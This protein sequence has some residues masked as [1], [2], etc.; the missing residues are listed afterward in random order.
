MPGDPIADLRSPSGS[1]ISV[2][3]NRPSP[4]GFGALVSDL[5]RPIREQSERLGRNVQK[6]VQ[7]DSDRIHRLVDRL[8]LEAAPAYAIFASD[9]D[10]IFILEPLAYSAVN[11]SSL[12]PRPY[13][14]P[15]RAAPR[16]LRA[17]IIVAD[18]AEARTFVSFSGLIDDVGEPLAVETRKANYGGF[19]GYDEHTVR[20]H[21]DEVSHRVWKEAGLRILEEHQRKAFDYIA[22]GS[23]EENC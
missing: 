23:H 8:E 16:G 13:M 4:G 19:S 3:I 20:G 22:I 1:L 14:R 17:G 11:V 9:L 5:V 21:A 10:D 2:F 15:L 12:G 18:R 6:S 7:S